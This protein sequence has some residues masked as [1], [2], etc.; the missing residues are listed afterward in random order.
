MKLAQKSRQLHGLRQEQPALEP[1]QKG[2]SVFRKRSNGVPQAIKWAFRRGIA[3]LGLRQN[4][5]HG[6]FEREVGRLGEIVERFQPEQRQEP[7]SGPILGR[8]IGPLPVQ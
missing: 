1:F 2:S 7:G 5:E 4:H 3:P 8:G 6:L